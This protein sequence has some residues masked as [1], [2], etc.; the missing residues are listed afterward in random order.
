MSCSCQPEANTRGS[1]ASVFAV[2]ERGSRAAST[3]A[4]PKKSSQSERICN[5]YIS[6]LVLFQEPFAHRRVEETSEN[7]YMKQYPIQASHGQ[8]QGDAVL[9]V[10]SA[11]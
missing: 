5:G 10:K 11:R 4:N 2:A 1:R 6:S 8:Q 3:N 7:R 9:P